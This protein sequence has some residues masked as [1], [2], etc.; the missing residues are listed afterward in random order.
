MQLV[1][2]TSSQNALIR[3]HFLMMLPVHQKI[4]YKLLLSCTKLFLIF[5]HIFDRSLWIWVNQSAKVYAHNTIWRFRAHL[6]KL[7]IKLFP[8]LDHVYG[9]V[10]LFRSGTLNQLISL[11]SNLKPICI[12]SIRFDS[13]RFDSIQFNSIRFDSIQFNSIQFNSISF[14]SISEYNIKYKQQ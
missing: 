2:F 8:L 6:K 14:V 7:A 11:K 5:L 12:Y 3:L 4:I 13:I 1:S 10:F 9:T